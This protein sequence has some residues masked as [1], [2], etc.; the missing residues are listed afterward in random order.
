MGT[1][2]LKFNG[3][4]VK[5]HYLTEFTC[6]NCQQA[7]TDQDLEPKNYRLI[8]SDHANEISKENGIFDRPVYGLDFWLKGVEHKICPA[9][10]ASH[11]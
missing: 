9:K 3:T 7:I 5:D 1:E 6:P 4:F 8:V 11:E 10:E 2:I